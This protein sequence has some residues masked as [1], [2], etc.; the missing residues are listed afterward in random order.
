MVEICPNMKKCPYL[1]NFCET[2]GATRARPARRVRSTLDVEINNRVAVSLRRAPSR[3]TVD[4][5]VKIKIS[6]FDD[7][8]ARI[9]TQISAQACSTVRAILLTPSAFTLPL[10]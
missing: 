7:F 6:T 4:K 2:L 10:R 1:Y 8:C 3:S 5:R 9:D